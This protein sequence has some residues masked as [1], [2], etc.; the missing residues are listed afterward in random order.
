VTDPDANATEAVRKTGMWNHSS[1][2]AIHNQASYLMGRERVQARIAQ[3][4]TEALTMVERKRRTKIT[5][6]KILQG[7]TSIATSDIRKAL[8]P[9]EDWDDETA[10]AVKSIQFKKDGEVRIE[11]H[12]KQPALDALAAIKGVT[13]GIPGAP[14]QGGVVI[15]RAIIQIPDNGRDPHLRPTPPALTNGG[16][17]NGAHADTERVTIDLPSNGTEPVH[18]GGLFTGHEQPPESEQRDDGDDGD[19]ERDLGL[20]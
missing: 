12:A 13:K 11:M 8:R 18:N 19:I 10:E 16:V 1:E 17:V 15:E 7:Y 3:L 20:S 5:A 6:E 9:P 4:R 14:M 2:Q